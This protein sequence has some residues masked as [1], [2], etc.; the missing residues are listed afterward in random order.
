MDGSVS[1]VTDLAENPVFRQLRDLGLSD[2]DSVEE[3]MPRIR[4]AADIR[5][6][7]CQR[8][9]VLF[10]S[11]VRDYSETYAESDSNQTSSASDNKIVIHD[12]STRHE[13]VASR[14]ADEDRRAVSL[15]PLVRGKRWVD[16]GAGR[17][18]TIFALGEKAACAAAVE[19]NAV[20]RERITKAGYDAFDDI[21]SLPRESSFEIATFMHV[22]EHLH[23]PVQT[24]AGL[25]PHLMPGAVCLF[26]VRHANDALLRHY[27]CP[28]YRSFSL[29]KQHI[30]LHTKQSLRAYLEAAG[31]IDIEITSVQR[32]PLANH[33]YWL[34]QGKPGGQLAWK[35]LTNP[36]LDA[37]YAETLAAADMTDT[38]VATGR[39][40]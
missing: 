34:S 2:V 8:S 39:R 23:A 22:F 6:L 14:P 9:G 30:L 18:E 7:Q 3:F 16:I 15:L 37:A 10:L 29:G 21:E 27:D 5:V 17:G 1:T 33:L 38:L 19:P 40:S 12:G 25:L 24:L 36:A 28:A 32:Y 31:L 26:E 13:I 11:D 35:H 20:L 4:D